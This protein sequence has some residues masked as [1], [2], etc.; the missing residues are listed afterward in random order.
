M[1][2]GGSLET[3]TFQAALNPENQLYYSEITS[4]N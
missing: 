2:W 4:L 1:N 3:P